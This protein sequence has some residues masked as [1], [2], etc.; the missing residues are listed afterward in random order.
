MNRQDVLTILITFAMGVFFGFYVY[1]AGF[2]PTTERVS[3]AIEE[4]S[5][6]L[7]I[8]GEVFGGCDRGVCPSFNV[9]SDGSY[10]YLYVPM[11]SDEA[12]LREG[13]LPFALQQQ[14]ERNLTPVALA[15]QSVAIEPVFCESFVDG[16]DVTYLVDLDGESYELSSC[17]TD[18]IADSPAWQALSNIWTYFE[19][20]VL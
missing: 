6:D 7:T 19:R 18:V 5:S 17:G 10:R 2:A 9:A 4:A 12:V 13:V 16:I 11:G 8:T 3:K 20:N 15:Q 14:L 1:L